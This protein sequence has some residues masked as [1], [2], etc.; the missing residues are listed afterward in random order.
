MT[1]SIDGVSGEDSANSATTSARPAGNIHRRAAARIRSAAS[2]V[3]AN[4]TAPTAPATRYSPQTSGIS[5]YADLGR[6]AAK[7]T[8]K[9]MDAPH[10][11][12]SQDSRARPGRR[13]G[14][15]SGNTR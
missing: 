14:N 4:S 11:A 9:P 8:R 12:S 7:R 15:S 2:D 6:N 5:P 13:N 3:S 10:S 1:W